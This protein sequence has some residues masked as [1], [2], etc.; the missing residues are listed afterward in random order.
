MRCYR[1]PVHHDCPDANRESD[2]CGQTRSESC[3]TNAG[4][5]FASLLQRFRIFDSKFACLLAQRIRIAG[6]LSWAA[7]QS[8]PSAGLSLIH[9]TPWHYITV[10]GAGIGLLRGNSIDAGRRWFAI[11]YIFQIFKAR[12]AR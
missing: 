5:V 1:L 4:S 3:W 11:G 7:S 9:R 12:V 10:S 6:H 8:I 2:A